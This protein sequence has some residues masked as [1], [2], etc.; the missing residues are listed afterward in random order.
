MKDW[1]NDGVWKCDHC[2]AIFKVNVLGNVEDV[3]GCPFCLVSG[4]KLIPC[5]ENGN[6][7]LEE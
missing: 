5:D 1:Y 4:T 3:Q 2:G 6:E 7:S